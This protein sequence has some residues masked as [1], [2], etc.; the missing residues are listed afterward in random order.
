MTKQFRLSN[1]ACALLVCLATLFLCASPLLAQTG[2]TGSLTGTVTDPSGGVIVG[3]SVTVTSLGTGQ[4]RTATTDS[5]GTYRFGLLPAGTY[6]LKFSASG[7]KTAEV[8]TVTVASTESRVLNQAMEV[9]AQSQQVTVESTT[10]RLQTQNATVGTLVGSKEITDLPLSGRNYTQ[11]IDLSPGVVVNV[12]SASA[13]GNG[14]QD[15]NVNGSGSDQNN[16]LM[17]G[18]SQ[19][20]YGSGGGAQSGNFPG[21]GIPN[22]DSIEEF[23]IQTSQFDAGYGRNPGASVSVTTKSGTNNFHGAAWEFYRDNIFNGNDKFN[24]ESQAKFLEPNKPQPLSQNEFGGTFGGPI[25]KDKLFFFGSYQGFRQKNGVGSNGFATGVS[26]DV[27][28]LPFN[29]PDGTRGNESGSIPLNWSTVPGTPMCSYSDYRSYLGCVFGFNFGI[30][31]GQ[32]VNPTGSNIN[33]VAVNILQAPGSKGKFTNGFYFPSMPFSGGAPVCDWT[34]KNCAVSISVPLIANEDQYLGNSDWVANSK[35]TVSTRYFYSHDPQV[36]SMVCLG[37]FNPA[38]QCAPGAPEDATYTATN[39]VLKL[40][41]VLNSNLVNDVHT[42]FQ[43]QTTVAVGGQYVSSCSVGISPML[44]GG[45]SCPEKVPGANPSLNQIPS[46][47]IAGFTGLGG[48]WN[49]GGNFFA[50]NSTIFNTWEAADNLS[51][52]H[53]KHTI[54]TGFEYDRIQ[55]NGVLPGRAGDGFLGIADFLTSSSGSPATGTT[56]GVNTGGLINFTGAVGEPQGSGYHLRVNGFNAFVQDDIKVTSKLTVNAGVRWEYDGWPTNAGGVFTNTWASQAALVNTG[57]FFLG[58][59]VAKGPG[60]PTDANQVGTLVGFVV[61]SNYNPNVTA[62]GTTTAPAACGMTAPA[63]VFTSFLQTNGTG[64]SATYTYVGGAT[65]VYTN[66]NKTL[67]HGFPPYAFAPRFGFAWQAMDKM[68][69][70]GGYGIFYDRVYG[71]LLSNN[72]VGNPPGNA[73]VAAPP[74]GSPN[75]QTLDNAFPVPTTYGWTP[76][77]LWV[78]NAADPV[79][80]ATTILGLDGGVGLGTTSD[81]EWLQVPLIQEYNVD[82]QYQ[83]GHNWVADIG[84][85]GTHG[86]HLYNWNQPINVGFLVPGG[87]N[88]PTDPQN[89]MM[90]VG[91]PFRGTPSSLPFNDPGNTNFETQI[92]QNLLTNVAGRVSYL[93]FGTGGVTNTATYGDSVYNSLQASLKHQFASGFFLQASYTWS[94]LITNINS[95]ISGAGISAG[96]NVL[97]GNSGSNDPL[98]LSQQYGPAAFNRSQRLVIAYSYNL[99]WKHTEGFSG[100]ALGGWSISGVTTIQNG[101]PFTVTD[102]SAG[103]IYYGQGVPGSASIPFGSSQGRAELASF[104]NCNANGVCKSNVPIAT[105]G[106][107]NS[108]LN[109]WINKAAFTAPPCIGGTIEGACLASGGGFGWGNSAVGSITGPGQNNWDLSI[110]KNTQITE[111][112][113]LQFRSEFYNV[114]NHAQY[115]P[116]S[117]NIN[118]A[119]FGQITSSSVP[120][121]VIQFGLKLLF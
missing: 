12:A 119:S 42:S 15:I 118:S 114:W 2:T 73:P 64:P 30:G 70:R 74:P 40:A 101:N 47:S 89:K 63:G 4:E 94:K 26:S 58:N 17:D 96:G 14:T 43:R 51:W 21:I 87:N 60:T 39:A 77:T 71:N 98:N 35:N 80:G 84:Y 112:L 16:Y 20:N 99:P 44:N 67:V 75:A 19:T 76:R 91:Q 82:L 24:K 109:G 33:Q 95:S 88:G 100:K 10:E 31:T 93:G 110:I 22:P 48:G 8:P 69:L 115:N 86:T 27:T 105:S 54:R 113:N 11:I 13:I 65:G 117:N 102:N 72:Q 90:M 66:T 38:N 79:N 108:R 29:L 49:Q 45:Q 9:G 104:G 25:K 18:V 52:N 121:R 1:C 116:P 34:V 6:K 111:A 120:P 36:Q 55:D 106:S 83:V 23:R 68:V 32:L 107:N 53:G 59:Q 3:A 103:M 62:C 57:S 78:A 85:V 37:L 56:P 46:F 7:F 61:Q 50:N 5:V 81:S 41:T 92:H 28:F 97:S